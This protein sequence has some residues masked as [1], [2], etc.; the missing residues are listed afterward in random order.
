[1]AMARTKKSARGKHRWVGFL[2]EREISKAEL[3]K[4][5]ST[6]LTSHSWSLFDISSRNGNTTA[7]LKTPLAEH[8]DSVSGLNDIDGI[9]TL[10]S[11]GKIN[12][13]RKRIEAIQSE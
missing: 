13:V 8:R 4:M 1:M 12:L 6:N 7:I 11:S 2:V 5:L 9:E 10:T 3:N